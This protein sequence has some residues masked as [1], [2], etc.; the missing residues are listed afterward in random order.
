MFQAPSNRGARL[1]RLALVL[2]ALSTCSCMF[3]K[4]RQQDPS[5]EAAPPEGVG[6]IEKIDPAL[7]SLATERVQIQRILTGYDSLDAP[8]Y[9]REGYLLFSDLKKDIIRKW[10]PDGVVA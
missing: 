5:S 10:T 2:L 3:L 4:P 6:S 9:S 8:F 7:R 1:A